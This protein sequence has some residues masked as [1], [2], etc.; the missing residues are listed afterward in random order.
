MKRVLILILLIAANYPLKG[1]NLILNPGFEEHGA[2]S[3]NGPASDNLMGNRVKNWFSPTDASPDY[4]LRND[5]FLWNQYGA[6]LSKT[7][8]AMAGIVVYGEKKDYREYIMGELSAPLEEGETYIFSIAIALASH[9]GKMIDKLGVYFSSEMIFDKKNS[10]EIKVIPQI[11]IDSTS[12][13]KLIGNWV[14]LKAT[15]VATGGEKH[16]I[17]GNFSSDKKTISKNV[18]DGKGAPYAYYY[19]DDISLE[20]ENKIISIEEDPVITLEVDTVKIAAGK[21]LIA[22]NIYFETDKSVLKTESYDM[23]LEI[24]NA[25]KV[26]PDLKVEIDG[27]T[28]SDGKENHNQKLSEDR[29][30][31]V[32]AYFVENGIAENRIT[33][34]GFGSSRPISADK[35][36]NRRVEFVFYE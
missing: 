18:N 14:I 28:D 25:L 3:G 5:D 26:Q 8:D 34:K 33:T 36:K 13:F 24:I 7:G 21:T 29:A 4:F 32:K 22:D 15:Y 11:T 23:L 31:A 27:H 1:Q 12:T 6:P 9:S 17:I 16:I 35:N 20:L 19:I 30:K 2:V 10:N